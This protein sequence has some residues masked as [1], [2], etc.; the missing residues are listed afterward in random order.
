M[1]YLANRQNFKH[2]QEC[3]DYS[4]RDQAASNGQEHHIYVSKIEVKNGNKLKIF[5]I[6]L[7]FPLF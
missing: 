2:M 7:F 4:P 3:I 1:I 6:N 5:S